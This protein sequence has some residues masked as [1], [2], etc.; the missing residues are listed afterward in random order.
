MV[1]AMA[2]VTKV[3][4]LKNLGIT[5]FMRIGARR[6]PA[7]NAPGF[8][9]SQDHRHSSRRLDCGS[10]DPLIESPFTVPMAASGGAHRAARSPV[11]IP[12]SGTRFRRGGALANLRSGDHR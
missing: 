1:A 8:I 5:G 12:S 6:A 4:R 3:T 9:I 10:P 2:T 7:E 11:Y